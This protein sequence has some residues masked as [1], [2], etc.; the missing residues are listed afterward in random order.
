MLA[1]P[2]DLPYCVPRN[3]L[4]EDLPHDFPRGSGA[5]WPVP[6]S[7]LLLYQTMGVRL[8]FQLSGV[9]PD[10]SGLSAVMESR[11][12]MSARSAPSLRYVLSGSM[13]LHKRQ[14]LGRSLTQCF[15]TTW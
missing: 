11:L 6:Q 9:S 13:D 8:A 2:D 15:L 7:S 3:A 14:F 10:C 12:I 4:Q 5:D 1:I